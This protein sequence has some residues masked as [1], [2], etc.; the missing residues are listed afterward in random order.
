MY[1]ISVVSASITQKIPL[2]KKICPGI[3]EEFFENKNWQKKQPMQQDA[4]K[5]FLE[6]S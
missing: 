2:I 4:F 6:P 3:Y 1:K 5:R